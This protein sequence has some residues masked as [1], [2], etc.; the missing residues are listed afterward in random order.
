LPSKATR[1]FYPLAEADRVNDRIEV[2]TE[3]REKDLIRA[4]PGA[5]WMQGHTWRLPLTWTACLTLRGVFGD[6]LV[7]GDRLSEWAW[8]EHNFRVGPALETRERALDPSRNVPGDER[9]RPYQRTGVEFLSVSRGAV[10]ADE[11]GLGKSVEAIMTLEALDAYPALIVAPKSVKRVWADEFEKWTDRSVTVVESTGTRRAKQLVAE[12]DVIIVNYETLRIASRLAPYGSIRL[13]DKERTEGPLNRP[14]G[15]VVADEAHRAK[16]PKAKQ[17]RALW[18]VGA[19]A[20]VRFA[21]TGTP[22]ANEPQD[23]WSLLHFVSPDEWPSRSQYIDRYVRCTPNWHGG[24]SFDGL[25]E[26]LKS[27]FFAAVDP[28]FLRRPKALVLTDMPPKTYQRR[29]VEMQPKQAKAYKQM[30]DDCVAQLDGGLLGAFDNFTILTRQSQ[31]A[32]AYA[33]LTPDGVRLS[34]PSSKCDAV[35]ELLEDMGDEQLVVFAQSKQL[36]G[37]LE[38]RLIKAEIT[39]GRVTGDERE[40]VRADNVSRFQGGHARVALCTLG[41]GSV[42]ITL[43]AASTV[44]FMQRSFNAVD[45]AQAEDRIHRIGQTADKVTIV[46]LIAPGTVEET[47]VLPSLE[48]KAALLEEVTRDRDALRRVLCR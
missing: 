42:G 6:R 37:L 32:S 29:Y 12:T 31:F 48:G 17:T 27:E 16:D 22:V 44:C 36:I 21:L 18:A 2:V 45:N 14:W 24:V 13:T 41:A 3:Y 9:L 35:M 33:E 5:K 19:R 47:A 25:H 7:I 10:L 46:D 4:V 15:A 20:Q 30:T 28:R 1:R 26:H 11:M 39:Y 38:Q 23:L 8:E 40:N 43:T 34:E